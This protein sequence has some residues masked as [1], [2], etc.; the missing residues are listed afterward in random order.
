MY[1]AAHYI[2]AFLLSKRKEVSVIESDAEK[3]KSQ[4]LAAFT[5]V[6]F[7]RAERA[8]SSC[9]GEVIKKNGLTPMQFGVL[10]VLYS[11]GPLH[12]NE[13]IDAMLSTSGNMTVVIKNMERDGLVHRETDPNDR[14]SGL[15]SL[16]DKGEQ[17]IAS[18]LPQH[19]ALLEEIFGILTAQE[20]RQLIQI[21]KKFKKVRKQ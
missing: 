14:R 7:R 12:I 9:E 17:L 4:R 1:S 21:L 2:K 8:I 19:I 13:I 5:M 6:A 10:D 16:T 15:V 20:Q 3:R 11:K 18:I